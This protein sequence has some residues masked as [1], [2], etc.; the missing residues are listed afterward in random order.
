MQVKFNNVSIHFGEHPILDGV[1]FSIENKSRIAIIG[2]N[3]A[4]KSTLLKLIQG[5]IEPDSGNI[6]RQSG[7]KIAT[8]Q[9]HVPRDLSGTSYDFVSAALTDEW[10]S[11]RIDIVL[12]QLNIDPELLLDNASGGQ[13]RRCL[14]A[15]SLVNEPDILL[16]D[17]PTNH[18]DIDSIDWL[19]KFLLGYHKTIIFITHDRTF[20]QAIAN[21]II[22]I[23][24]GQIICWDGNYQAFLQH[25]SNQ[26]HE[27][28]KHN[29][30]FDKKLAQEEIWIRQ[31]IKARRT[32]NEGR[33]RALEKMRSERAARRTRQGSIQVAQQKIDYAGKIAFEIEGISESYP[34]KIIINNFSSTI[35]RG[36]KVGIIGPNGCGKTTLLNIILGEQQ[37]QSGYVKQGTRM[38]IAYFDQ[39]REKLDLEKTAID[40]VAAGREEIEINGKKKHVLSY[41]Q[42]FLFTPHK[43]R[44]L[45]KSLS[46][47][48]RNRLLLARILSKPSN[49]LVLDEPT[50]DLDMET[51]DILEEFLL[52]YKGTL[53][54][55]SHDRTLLN[56]VVTSTIVFEG[57]GLL[58]EYVGGYDDWIKQSTK[59]TEEKT[60][61]KKGK[62][63]PKKKKSNNK[64]SY[65]HELE[66]KELPG[67]IELL[68]EKIASLTNEIN[69]PSFYKNNQ[70]KITETNNML[71][72]LQAQLEEAFERWQEL[73]EQ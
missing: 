54:L 23:D 51:L 25:K 46:G 21:K 40:N 36:D 29:K 61:S 24:L 50:N 52:N 48:E 68:E 12:S 73:D 60:P 72:S 41:L 27:E 9:Q 18:L 64:L 67:K 35:M 69:E 31:G 38:Q 63:Q 47:G 15:Q 49:L 20:M 17:E 59:Q 56:N 13:I 4:G 32:R 39:H 14:L 55:V 10:E 37:P 22:E 71:K 53:L 62:P 28:E 6:E 45:V 34:E 70:S 42:D 65:K 66:L 2:R 58:Q 30:L 7:I 1:N 26:L 16:L 57:K 8:M 11:Y 33:V 3:G 43:A 44:S 5:S 19:E